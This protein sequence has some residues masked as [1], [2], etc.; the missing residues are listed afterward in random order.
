M[1]AYNSHQKATTRPE[2]PT[3]LGEI[4]NNGRVIGQVDT[5]R[6]ITTGPKLAT[7]EP[8]RRKSSRSGRGVTAT[9]RITYKEWM[10]LPVETLVER[11]LLSM[12]LKQLELRC[13]NNTVHYVLNHE[14]SK[15][16]LLNSNELRRILGKTPK[17]LPTP[18]ILK[19]KNV[20]ADCD[21][22]NTRLIKTFRRFLCQD[23]IDQAKA[24]SAM[25]GILQWKPAQF[26]YT[27]DYYSRYPQ[28]FFDVS[29]PSGSFWTQHQ[30]KCP[31]LKFFYSIF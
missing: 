16:T 15:D 30:K 5:Y 17:F 3:P 8:S 10:T 7:Q 1:A 26:P 6:R 25:A 27:S 14:H 13:T 28:E 20:A 31:Q 19:P 21:I 22:F 9:S 11:R 18:R 24:S 4:R 23:F 2:E 29:K 12:S